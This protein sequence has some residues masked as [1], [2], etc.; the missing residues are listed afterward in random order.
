MSSEK[1]FTEEEE[2]ILKVL[3]ENG[4]RL[5]SANEIAEELYNNPSRPTIAKIL[6][7][8]KK[9]GLIEEEDDNEGT[10]YKKKNN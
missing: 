5:M 10:S 6:K 8:L 1:V 9:R 7:D 4:G 2:K 3:I